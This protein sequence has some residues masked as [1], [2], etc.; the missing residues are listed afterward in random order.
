[1]FCFFHWRLWS[2]ARNAFTLS[3]FSRRHNE[4]KLSWRYKKWSSNRY[5][6]TW[7]SLRLII[8]SWKWTNSQRYKMWKHITRHSR[9][10]IHWGFRSIWEHQERVKEKDICWFTML[11]GPWN[12]GLIR[13]W[14]FCWYMVCRSDCNWTCS[15]RSSKCWFTCHEGHSLNS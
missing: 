11:D 14:F 7:S 13:S 4:I 3:G 10:C 15:R 8:F 9:K 2:L 5:N 6:I 12:N 1:M